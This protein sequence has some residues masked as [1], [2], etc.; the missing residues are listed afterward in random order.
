MRMIAV[1]LKP[2]QDLKLELEKAVK[3]HSIYSGFIGTCV[4]SLHAVALRMAGAR[5]EKQDIRTLEG[6]FE[7]ISLVGTVSINGTHL[8]LSVSG[9]E[10]EVIGGH[11][12]EGSII[13]TTAEVVICYDESIVFERVADQETGFEELSV[14]LK[15]TE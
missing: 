11:L 14:K 6:H 3:D 1:R 5:P 2:N 7:I 9:A 4:G 10:G 12:K 13:T 15:P 8:H